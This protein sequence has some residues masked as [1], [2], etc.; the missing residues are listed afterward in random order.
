MHP[1]PRPDYGA[2]QRYLPDQTPIAVDL[3]DNRNLWGA[4]PAAVEAITGADGSVLSHYPQAYGEDLSEAV[5]SSLEVDT[6]LIT[7]GGGASG[8]LDA[9]MR[10]CAPTDVRFLTPGWPS[11]CALARMN[12]HGCAPIPWDQGLDDPRTLVGAA[13]SIVFIPNPN[14]PTGRTVPDDW[15]REAQRLC[16]ELGSILI[17]DEAYGEY[18]RP[19]GD[20]TA[21]QL[22]L[23]GERTLCVKTLSKAYG[24]A[25][26]RIGYGVGSR[27]LILE[28]DKA[29]GPF[30]V[31]STS[32]RAGAAALRSDDPWL[33]DVVRETKE[34]R[35]RLLECLRHR[36]CDPPDSAANFVFVPFEADTVLDTA[37]RLARF[38]VR[39]RP[40]ARR[41]DGGSG[42][43]ATV[44][45]WEAMQRLLDGLDLVRS[46]TL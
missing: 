13:P 19:L 24:L 36:G 9:T 34:N 39:T 28:I 44:A 4:H 7:T 25:G 31:S 30:T 16:E 26:L 11:A 1:Y 37:G 23:A 43:R 41:E 12:G 10:A 27:E 18:A 3:S 46:G 20:R 42:L 38:G 14:N 45:P 17:L 15:I 40:F 5:A 21:F 22:A 8:I 32:G 35:D 29:R 2:L 6:D 33:A